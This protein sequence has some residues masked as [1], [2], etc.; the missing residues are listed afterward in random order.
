[1]NEEQAERLAS[2]VVEYYR[3][4]IGIDPLRFVLYKTTKF[5]PAEVA[6]FEAALKRIPVT[7]FVNLRP[8]EFRLVRRGAYPPRRG[9]MVSVNE[10]TH[11]LLTNGYYPDW[12]TYMG[13]HIP[14]PY[15][16]TL[17]G[18]ADP[19]RVCN[20]VLGL[21]KLNWN[22]ARAFTSVPIPLRFARE[23]G[24]IMSHYADQKG[25]QAEPKPAYRFYM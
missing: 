23:V 22:T 15:E 14:V 7:E 19:K 20:D 10:A 18:D 4:Q 12:N 3:Q 2:R 21:T 8:S 16:V 9:T 17:L 13:A 25:E 6:G 1:L 11:F 24:S 5:A